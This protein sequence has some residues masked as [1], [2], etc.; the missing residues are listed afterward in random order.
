MS[1]HTERNSH[2]KAAD[3]Y[4]QTAAATD[5]RALEARV[6]LKAAQKLEILSKKLETDGDAHFREVGEALEY[7]QKLWTVFASDA[8]D[9][10]HHLPQDI[11]NNIASLAVFIFKRTQDV[12]I[13]PKA[14]KLKV[15]ININ[16]NIASGLMKSVTA[17]PKKEDNGAQDSAQSTSS[18][19]TDSMA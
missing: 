16:R 15:L 19:T 1:E 5:P 14:E 10:T 7:N 12:L 4:G 3:A 17:S 2:Y 8:A 13:E 18:K 11:K 9:D 6:L